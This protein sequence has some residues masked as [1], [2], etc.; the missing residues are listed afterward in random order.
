[1]DADNLS[2]PPGAV[3]GHYDLPMWRSI[4]GHA[5]ELPCCADCGRFHYPPGP[6]CPHCLSP[7]LVWKPLSGKGE[8][9]SWV[10]FERTYLERYPAPYKV[11][12]V[13]LAEG[14]VMISNPEPLDEAACAIGAKVRL[15][16]A[17]LDDHTIL[18]RFRLE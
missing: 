3:L 11:I 13:R 1:M 4:A 8:I 12:A 7:A 5:M 16:Y 6:A 15:V 2:F 14:P 10:R 9:I 18:P 17:E